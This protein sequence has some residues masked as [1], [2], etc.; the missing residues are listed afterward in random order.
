MGFT[1]KRS[2]FTEEEQKAI[3]ECHKPGNEFIA[4]E[5][6]DE[7]GPLLDE[8]SSPSRSALSPEIRTTG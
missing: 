3:M 7:D 6:L 4:R 1:K 5:Y 8:T 2:V